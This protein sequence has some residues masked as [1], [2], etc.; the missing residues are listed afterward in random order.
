MKTVIK[1]AAVA[2][3]VAGLGYVTASFAEPITPEAKA[4][5][6]TPGKALELEI[7]AQHAVS[8]FEP[9]EDGCGLTVVL[10]SG[11]QGEGGAEAHGTRIVIPVGA[12]KTVRID[13]TERRSADFMC[14]PHGKKMNA[15]V[16]DREAYKAAKS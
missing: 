16:Y 10:A 8:Y 14:G 6:M 15:R 3:M 7:G 5:M 11:K 4:I 9:K 13:G 2:S 1:I 12:G